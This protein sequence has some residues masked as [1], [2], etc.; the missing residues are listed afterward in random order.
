MMATMKQS[1]FSYPSILLASRGSV[2][3]QISLPLGNEKNKKK[4]Q[5]L[6][7]LSWSH[8]F[9]QVCSGILRGTQLVKLCPRPSQLKWGK[10]LKKYLWIPARQNRNGPK[11]CFLLKVLHEL[12]GLSLKE[13]DPELLARP[14]RARHSAAAAASHDSGGSSWASGTNA[15]FYSWLVIVRRDV[16][17]WNNIQVF[18]QRKYTRSLFG[19]T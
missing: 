11:P 3:L 8:S 19:T 16:F 17:S 12:L 14:Q 10:R 6:A 2:F 15:D 9:E 4:R 5:I 18:P 1:R 13:W 7:L